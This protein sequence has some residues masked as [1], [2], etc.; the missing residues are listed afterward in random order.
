[1][2]L[3]GCWNTSQDYNGKHKGYLP[4]GS[5]TVKSFFI[6]YQK[7]DAEVIEFA[8]QLSKEHDCFLTSIAELTGIP[9][10]YDRRK[11]WSVYDIPVVKEKT[12]DEKWED[13]R[14]VLYKASRVFC[15]CGD[16]QEPN[17]Y[18]DG[19]CGKCANEIKEETK[20]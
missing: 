19:F 11:I 18:V 15:D 14:D 17:K 9:P 7:D 10:K 6:P 12:E 3:I 5:C 4:E 8:K 1:M 16:K 20:I 13:Y 2:S